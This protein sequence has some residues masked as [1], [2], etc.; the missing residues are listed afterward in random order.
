M[1]ATEPLAISNLS[2]FGFDQGIIDSGYPAVLANLF[3]SPVP[4][5]GPAQ[6]A[7]S[8][9]DELQAANLA[10]IMPENG[11]VYPATAMGDKLKQV[12]QLIKSTLPVEVICLDSDSWDHHEN[13]PTTFSSRWQNLPVPWRRFTPIWDHRCSVLL[14]W[15]IPSSVVE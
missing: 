6:A 8:A 4:F 15:Y 5:F 1:G 3:H 12:S 9:M 13:L 11:A 10:A 14:C 2:D 7:L